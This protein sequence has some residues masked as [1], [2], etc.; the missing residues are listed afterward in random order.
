MFPYKSLSPSFCGIDPK[1][2][3]KSST[4]R[5]REPLVVVGDESG[6]AERDRTVDLLTVRPQPP[7]ARSDRRATDC[8]ATHQLPAQ[9]P[10]AFL[11]IAGHQKALSGT[12][13]GTIRPVFSRAHDPQPPSTRMEVPIPSAR[14]LL[15]IARWCGVFS[16]A[17]SPSESVSGSE[18][19]RASHRRIH[20]TH[21]RAKLLPHGEGRRCLESP[22]HACGHPRVLHAHL[23][24]RNRLTAG[25]A[26]MFHGHRAVSCAVLMLSLAAS[27]SV[28]ARRAETAE[29]PRGTPDRL[30]QVASLIERNYV[31][32]VDVAKLPRGS[33]QEM[34]AALDPRCSSLKRGPERA[35]RS[36]R[37]R[38]RFRAER[39]CHRV[40]LRPQALRRSRWARA[41]TASSSWTT[42]HFPN[43]C[44]GKTRATCLTVPSAR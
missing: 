28:L 13:N 1:S 5:A 24:P 37:H 19:M 29:E 11:G 41:G 20:S 8:E 4:R 14:H 26:A 27:T 32:A 39:Q 36:N 18:P 15:S 44:P 40:S 38:N 3:E 21:G 25:R 16:L 7:P 35:S 33:V 6:G 30:S 42:T 17:E 9:S 2:R 43:A 23:R 12:S 34:L 10:R 22:P 31:D